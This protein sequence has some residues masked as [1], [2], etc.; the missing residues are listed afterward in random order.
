MGIRAALGATPG[1]VVRLALAQGT[2]LAAIGLGLRLIVSWTLSG[3]L[4]PWLFD[5]RASD[6]SII[7]AAVVCLGGA[8]MLASWLPARRAGALDPFSVLR[9]S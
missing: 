8:S 6:P 3:Y 9:D 2:T 1:Q 5:T 7:V 4:R